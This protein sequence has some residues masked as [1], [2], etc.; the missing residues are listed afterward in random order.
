MLAVPRPRGQGRGRTGSAGAPNPRRV[1]EAYFERAK[2][3]AIYLAMGL[4][5]GVYLCCRSV[6]GIVPSLTLRISLEA[7]GHRVSLTPF[8]TPSALWGRHSGIALLG[9]AARLPS[10]SVATSS[11]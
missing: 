6:L 8:G 3:A 1:T 11:R 10:G 7:G 5:L 4:I 9:R 2:K